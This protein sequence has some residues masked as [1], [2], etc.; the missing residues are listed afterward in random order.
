[1]LV[2]LG[3]DLMT[4]E[5]PA[6]RLVAGAHAERELVDDVGITKVPVDRPALRLNCSEDPRRQRV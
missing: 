5:T 6:R 4:E 3:K 1:M 2:A